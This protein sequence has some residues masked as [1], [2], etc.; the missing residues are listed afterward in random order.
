[1][2]VWG[3]GRGGWKYGLQAGS[4]PPS[5]FIWPTVDLSVLPDTAGWYGGQTLFPNSS[6]SG[7]SFWLPLPVSPL[8]LDSALLPW[9]SSPSTPHPLLEVLG[10][11]GGQDI[12]RYQPGTLWT[13]YTW[14]GEWDGATGGQG[15]VSR[16]RTDGGEAKAGIAGQRQH[17]A[18]A[19]GRTV[20]RSLHAPAMDA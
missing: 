18:G 17:G 9:H 14:F 8:L 3:G 13:G 12:H 10:G 11:T 20:I 6:G 2:C 4:G 7:N 19:Q 5:D 15:A 16:S 1:M